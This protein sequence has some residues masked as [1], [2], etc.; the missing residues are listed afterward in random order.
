MQKEFTIALD[1]R[2][3]DDL[4]R[5]FYLKQHEGELFLAVQMDN[6][7]PLPFWR[8]IP[9]RNPDGLRQIQLQLGLPT[10]PVPPKRNEPLLDLSNEPEDDLG[11][12]RAM[13]LTIGDQIKQRTDL[14]YAQIAEKVGVSASTVHAVARRFQLKRSTGRKFGPLHEDVAALI[15]SRPEL[16][17][18]QIGALANVSART[19]ANTAKKFNLHRP[20]GPKLKSD[21]TDP[22]ERLTPG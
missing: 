5:K 19:V 16:T 14:S 12:V 18:A 1:V 8:L 17:Y 11:L 13:W 9:L 10:A 6:V 21:N 20:T 4:Y 7:P 22:V 3:D 2:N 15:Q